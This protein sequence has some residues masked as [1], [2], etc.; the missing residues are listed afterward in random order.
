[1]KSSILVAATGAML[2]MASPLAL[3]LEERKF[4]TSWVIVEQTVTVTG[5]VTPTA[6]PTFA[7]GGGQKQR[8][9]DTDTT[10]VVPEATAP[11]SPEVVIVTVTGPPPNTEATVATS[12]ETPTQE[13]TIA[14]PTYPTSTA[15]PTATAAPTGTSDYANVAVARHNI[16]RSNHSAPALTWSDKLAG[17]AA[18]TA[19]TCV[20]AH[21]MDQGDKGYGQNLAAWGSSSDA[22]ALGTDGAVK[23]AITGFWYN[24]EFNAYRPEYYDAAGPNMD[25]FESW[26]HFTQMLWKDAT[27]LGCVSQFCEAG[28]IYG[29][30]SWFTVCNYGPQGNV[31]GEYPTQV[32]KPLGKAVEEV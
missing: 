19:A 17:Y 5:T 4:E 32:L 16:H 12:T 22:L 13:T 27:E 23:M 3:S 15:E 28:T 29:I 25:T 18:N 31:G 7:F 26:G 20:F 9:S 2:A 21:D 30:D 1:M 6:K 24:G 8:P 11:N 14:T 10:T